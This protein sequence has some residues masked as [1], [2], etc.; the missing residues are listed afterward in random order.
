MAPAWIASILYYTAP[1]LSWFIAPQSAF[2][3]VSP[4]SCLRYAPSLVALV[5]CLDTFTVPH[6]YYDAVTYDLAQP[7]GSQREDWRIAIQSVLSSS[8]SCD[9]SAVPLSLR[10]LYDIQHFQDFC[11]FYEKASRC[12]TYLKGWGFFIVPLPGQG[13]RDIH[14]SAPHPGYDLGTVEQAAAIF[15]ATGAKSLLVP[16]RKRTAFLSNSECIVPSSPKQ[17]YHKTDTAHND[18]SFMNTLSIHNV[19][20]FYC[21]KSL[22]LMPM[23]LFMNGNTP[24]QRDVHRSPALF[25]SFTAKVPRLVLVMTY[26]CRQD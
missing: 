8:N 10:G 19:D 15:E 23:S 14:I 22:S 25:C 6:A 26:F 5:T 18:V 7:V 1:L 12:G 2:E 11:V 16:G 4:S 3:I 13:Y 17:D 21:S 20:I 9:S 24:S